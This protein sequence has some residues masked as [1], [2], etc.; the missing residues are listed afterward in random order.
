MKV[1]ALTIIAA[2]M[3]ATYFGYIGI[4]AAINATDDFYQHQQWKG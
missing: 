4:K 3:V 1:V 2:A